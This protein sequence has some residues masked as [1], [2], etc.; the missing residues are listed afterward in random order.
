MPRYPADQRHTSL[1][2]RI[3]NWLFNHPGEHRGRDI[4]AGIGEPTQPVNNALGRLARDGEVER[5]RESVEGRK[6]PI[7]Y[8]RFLK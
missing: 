7:T 6:V 3:R 1:P 4:A 5:R 8:Y 2:A